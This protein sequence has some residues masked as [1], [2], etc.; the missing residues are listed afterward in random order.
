[1]KS[2]LFASGI[3]IA[4][5]AL[6]ATLVA[7]GRAVYHRAIKRAGIATRDYTVLTVDDGDIH[8]RYFIKALKDIFDFYAVH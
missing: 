7:H 4:L 5:V 6:N 1:V 3:Q 8:A 2:S